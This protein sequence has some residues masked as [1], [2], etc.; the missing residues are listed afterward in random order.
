MRCFNWLHITDLHLGGKDHDLLWPTVRKS[1]FEDLAVLHAKAGPWHAVIFTGD[2]VQTGEASEFD[3]LEEQFIGPLWKRLKELGSGDAV[4]LPVPGNHDLFR[5]NVTKPSAALRL[6]LRG[7]GYREIADE[8]W[9]DPACEYREVVSSAFSAFR[10]WAEKRGRAQNLIMTQG[11]LPGDFLASLV[12]GAE[13]TDPI[14]IGIA[15]MN[16]AFLQLSGGN[17]HKRLAIDV[18]QLSPAC[19]GDLPHWIAMHNAAV[20]ITHHGPEWLDEMSASHAYPEINPSGRFATHLFGHMHETV[21]RT[22]S[23]GGGRTIRHWQGSS[24]CGLEKFGEAQQ[25]SRKHGYSAGRIDLS[26]DLGTIRYWPR[27]AVVDRNGC[28]FHPD[29]SAC[30]LDEADSGTIPELLRPDLAVRELVVRNSHARTR[31]S[32]SRIRGAYAISESVAPVQRD[33]LRDYCAAVT[34]AHSQIRFVEI[35]L[36]KDLSPIQLDSLYI[37]PR[38]SPQEIHPDLAPFRWPDT[39][40]GVDGI[41]NFNSLVILGDPGSGKSTLVSCLAWQLCRQDATTENHWI[42]RFGGLL[43]IP[44]ILRELRLK[45]DV[46]WEGLMEAFLEHHIGKLIPSRSLLDQVFKTGKAIILLDGLDEIGNLTVRK[47]LR[48]AVHSGMAA[49]PKCRWILTSRVIGYDAVPFHFRTDKVA[50]T[51]DVAGELLV[52]KKGTKTIRS[53]IADV[54]YLAPFSDEQIRQFSENWYSQHEPNSDVVIQNSRDFVDAIGE[55]D[56][57]RRLA[58][59]PYLLTLMALIHHKNARLPHGRTELYERIATAYLEQIDLRR[60]LDQLPYSLQQK[61]R[62]LAE[63]AYR[64]QLQRSKKNDAGNSSQILASTSSVKRWLKAA[65]KASSAQGTDKEAET[66]LDYFAKRSGLLLPRGEGMFAFMHLSLQEYF[67]A[68][69]IEPRLTASRFSGA[70]LP[71]PSDEELR[72]WANSEAW[73]ESFV[74]LFELI[75]QKS[76]TETEGFLDHL[77]RERLDSDSARKEVTAAGLLAEISTDPFVFLQAET[78]RRCIQESWRWVLRRPL[79]IERNRSFEPFPNLVVRCLLRATDGDLIKSWQ[80]G[81]VTKSE[82]SR[83]ESLD[84]SG[85]GSVTDLSPLS[86]LPR[87]RRLILK[88]CVGIKNFAPLTDLRNLE[89]LNLEGCESSLMLSELRNLK[90]LKAITLGSKVDL[91]LFESFQHLNELHLHYSEARD[92]DLTPLAGLEQLTFLCVPIRGGEP[93]IDPRLLRDPDLIKSPGLR[94]IILASNERI[95]RKRNTVRRYSRAVAR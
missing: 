34:K 87:L 91:A 28:R 5:P 83:A 70:H 19:D 62:W 54:L 45:A 25:L 71:E 39:Q 29:V 7:D 92:T 16:T 81:A 26:T 73:R 27:S 18:R 6:L 58:R 65:M 15:G 40:E 42:K 11:A 44:M 47:R 60:H 13:N 50:A 89:V 67:A 3:K 1:F 72:A 86:K 41:S 43:P 46:T 88:N 22:S 48:D 17:Y 37:E 63:V 4:L 35:P 30:V 55:N 32:V 75:S 93:K 53:K 64:M 36:Q 56:G 90:S 9:S 79:Q 2:A 52:E 69:F 84:L 8:F 77:F 57:T 49:F 38:L 61:K 33:D 66:L 82:L 95:G 21:M 59:I 68:C 74:L 51:A 31:A 20:L 24:L 23:L 94:Q 12:L 85:C 10:T 14:K 80:A 78:K 76:V